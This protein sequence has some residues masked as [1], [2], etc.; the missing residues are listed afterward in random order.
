MADL[1]EKFNELNNTTDI[2]VEF[3]AQDIEQNKG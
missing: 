3:D 2:T 1:E